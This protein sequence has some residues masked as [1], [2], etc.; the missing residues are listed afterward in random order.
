MSS[1]ANP[2]AM[3]SSVSWP[4]SSASGSL[5]S[6]VAPLARLHPTVQHEPSLELAIWVVT[7]WTGEITNCAPR[8]HDELRW[9]GAHEWPALGL[10]H[11]DYSTLL[12]KAIAAAATRLSA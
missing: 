12:A 2:T 3:P 10:A 11:P 9:F 1:L 8:E 7:E 4:R 5:G 6:H